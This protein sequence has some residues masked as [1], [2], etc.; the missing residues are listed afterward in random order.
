MP[1]GFIYTREENRKPLGQRQKL[2]THSEGSNQGN[3]IDSSGFL[4]P[5]PH[6]AAQGGPDGNY[7]CFWGSIKMKSKFQRSDLYSG[8]GKSTLS[9]R[10]EK[11]IILLSWNV[12]KSSWGKLSIN[13]TKGVTILIFTY[14][15]MQIHLLPGES[16][17]LSF[18]GCLPVQAFLED[19]PGAHELNM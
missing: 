2:C 7:T 10:L 15:G 1:Q 11:D 6:R 8:A 13:F 4:S 16:L 5:S 17:S 9:Y 3:S 14:L 12:S 19:S 18:Q